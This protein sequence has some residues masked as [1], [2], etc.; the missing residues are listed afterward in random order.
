MVAAAF[1]KS[2][3]KYNALF[4]CETLHSSL[5]FIGNQA[6]SGTLGELETY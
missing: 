5:R 4:L 1:R 3:V 6:F 2:A